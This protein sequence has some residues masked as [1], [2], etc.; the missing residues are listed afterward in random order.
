[1]E[2]GDDKIVYLNSS[3][4]SGMFL[5]ISLKEDS[6]DAVELIDGNDRTNLFEGSLS[7]ISPGDRFP[8]TSGVDGALGAGLMEESFVA[9]SDIDV[10]E[11]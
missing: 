8:S 5:S 4:L 11:T 9:E 2:R 6:I 1:M 7:V 3:N 10:S